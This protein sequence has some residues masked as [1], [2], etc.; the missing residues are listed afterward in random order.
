MPAMH[1]R[2]AHY[3]K[4]DA[5]KAR[6]AWTGIQRFPCNRPSNGSSNGTVLSSQEP[7]FARL[8]ETRLSAM[9]HSRSNDAASRSA[10]EHV[11]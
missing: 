8:P 9:K 11:A 2:E 7:I 1:P 10:I 4:L 3:L 6:P 5:S